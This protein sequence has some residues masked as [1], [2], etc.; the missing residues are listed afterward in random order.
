M[1]WLDSPAARHRCIFR[2][3][4]AF[5]LLGWYTKAA[6]HLKVFFMDDSIALTHPLFPDLMRSGTSSGV[7]YLLPLA[8]LA[9]I[10]FRSARSLQF[11]AGL[12]IACSGMLI[13]H[14][15]T[16]NDATFLT[17]FWVALWLL[18]LAFNIDGEGEGVA[19]HGCVLAQCVVGV[20]FLGGVVGKLTSEYWDGEVLHNLYFLQK[21]NWPYP[22]IR[23][24]LDPQAVRGWATGFSRTIIVIEVLMAFAP[25]YATRVFCVVGPLVM[26]GIVGVSTWT[27]FSVMGC[28]VGMLLAC[29]LWNGAIRQLMSTSSSTRSRPAFLPGSP[30]SRTSWTSTSSL[31][32]RSNSFPRSPDG[33]N[34]AS[35]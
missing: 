32:L 11:A 34:A 33:V 7:A 5:W 15:D 6:Q 19:L 25:F 16:C 24:S 3:A 14:I 28:M 27:L 30:G 12:L 8:I 1:K 9:M 26:L 31:L 35:S 4:A 23:E 21:S 13:L 2:V 17:S 18:W 29:L 10:G 20:A 22:W